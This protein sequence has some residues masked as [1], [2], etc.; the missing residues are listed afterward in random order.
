MYVKGFSMNEM[1]VV[2]FYVVVLKGGWF[3]EREVSFVIG[4]ECVS[5][6]CNEGFVVIEIDVG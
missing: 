4:W 1:I 2:G 3:V 5:V 6:F